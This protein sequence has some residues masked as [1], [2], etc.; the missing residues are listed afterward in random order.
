MLHEFCQ[1]AAFAV[2]IGVA[3]SADSLGEHPHGF[4]IMLAFVGLAALLA[5][6]GGESDPETDNEPED[7]E[8]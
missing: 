4:L 2:I 6:L 7:E 5:L 1:G 3:L 8:N